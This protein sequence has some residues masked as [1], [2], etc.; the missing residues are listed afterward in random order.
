[1]QVFSEQIRL[2]DDFSYFQAG[3]LKERK[4]KV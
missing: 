1:M 2:K 4:I 3:Q